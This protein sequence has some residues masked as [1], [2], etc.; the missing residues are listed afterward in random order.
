MTRSAD[1]ADGRD[2]DRPV[3]RASRRGVVAV[4]VAGLLA[5]CLVTS[6]EGGSTPRQTENGTTGGSDANDGGGSDGDETGSDG[7]GGGSDGGA[8]EATPDEVNPDGSGLVVPPN[9]S[10]RGK[11]SRSFEVTIRFETGGTPVR[12]DAERYAVD[13]AVRRAEPL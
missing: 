4:G 3:R 11:R 7:D 10:S 9:R 8:E 6:E 1:G 5:G 12:P 13:A 2:A